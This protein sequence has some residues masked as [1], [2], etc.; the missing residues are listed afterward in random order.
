[1]DTTKVRL[2]YKPENIKLLF[3]GESPPSSGKF[4]YLQSNMTIYTSRAFESVF[5]KSFNDTKSFLEYFQE[6]KCYLEDLTK[7]PVD[8][9]STKEREFTLK[10]GITELSL[11]LID[12]NPE[13]I[14]IVL[15]KIDK[16]VK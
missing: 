6:R 10:Q 9:M 15:K 16:Y 4:F 3:I 1:M 7:I 14:V 2:S 8:K 5:N 12:Y 11:K 13:A